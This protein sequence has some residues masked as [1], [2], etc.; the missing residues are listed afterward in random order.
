SLDIGGL[1]GLAPRTKLRVTAK[2]DDGSTFS[3]EVL[4]RLDSPIDVDYYKNGGILHTV[5]RGLI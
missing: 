3:F 5:L 2:R 4:A 1:S